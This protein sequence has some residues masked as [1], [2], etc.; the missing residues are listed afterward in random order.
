[1]IADLLTTS[2]SSSSEDAIIPVNH[3]PVA[4]ASSPTIGA[5]S[6]T[7]LPLLQSHTLEQNNNAASLQGRVASDSD[8][9]SWWDTAQRIAKTAFPFI[10][11]I[12]A[13]ACF[14]F[15]PIVAS[16]VGCVLLILGGIVLT[17]IAAESAR[18]SDFIVRLVEEENEKAAAA[19][20]KADR[21]EDAA[22]SGSN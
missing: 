6:N 4:S 10:C 16:T 13:L 12:G 3:E 20:A 15:C 14:I 5:T 21:K 18:R 7:V 19:K 8:E 17:I 1:M 9:E 22:P 11:F 2:S